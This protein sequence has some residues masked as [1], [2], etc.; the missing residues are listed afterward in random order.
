MIDAVEY[1]WRLPLKGM[2]GRPAIP[3]LI[4]FPSPIILQSTDVM[5]IYSTHEP[6]SAF[7]SR[8][9]FCLDLHNE[10]VRAMRFEPDAHKKSLESA[11][12]RKERLQQEQELAQHIQVTSSCPG[13]RRLHLQSIDIVRLCVCRR[14]RTIFRVSLPE[15]I[16]LPSSRRLLKGA[17]RF[18]SS[19]GIYHSGMTRPFSLLDGV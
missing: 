19:K 1:H 12:A 7:H 18:V 17:T 10:A 5:D 4:P 2:L 3:I 9:S 6:M 13:H 14:K 15:N 8:V 16:R 11:E